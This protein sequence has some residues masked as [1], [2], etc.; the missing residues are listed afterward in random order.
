MSAL[1]TKLRCNHCGCRL[2]DPAATECPLCHS[3]LAKVGVSSELIEWATIRKMGR[4]R[5]VWRHY[6]LWG[7]GMLLLVVS[8]WPFWR[9]QLDWVLFLCFA[10]LCFGLGYVG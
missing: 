10:I 5:F 9:G 8:F 3:E 4:A 2:K 1:S 6:V 7:G